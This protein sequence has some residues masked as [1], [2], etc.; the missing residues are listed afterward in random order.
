MYKAKSKQIIKAIGVTKISV[1]D[2]VIAD[3]SAT[4][5]HALAHKTVGL[6]YDSKI[7]HGKVAGKIYYK[8]SWLVFLLLFAILILFIKQHM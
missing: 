7:I 5:V 4:L 8:I 6:L 2:N 3:K 1:I